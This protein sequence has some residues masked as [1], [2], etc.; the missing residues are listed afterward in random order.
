[1]IAKTTILSCYLGALRNQA[2]LR[3]SSKSKFTWSN[4]NKIKL[5]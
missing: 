1:M 5:E 3:N 2:T 4:W